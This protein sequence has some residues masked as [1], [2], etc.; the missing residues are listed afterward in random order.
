MLTHKQATAE[1]YDEGL[2]LMREHMAG[3]QEQTMALTGMT[4]EESN[5]LCRTVGEV[6]G[7]YEDGRLAGFY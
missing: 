2:Q 5:T 6:A 4:W 1:Q 3:Y 7:V